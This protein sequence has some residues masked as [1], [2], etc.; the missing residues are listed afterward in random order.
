MKELFPNQKQYSLNSAIL[1]KNFTLLLTTLNRSPYSNSAF[2]KSKASREKLNF[3]QKANSSTPLNR[4]FFVR[5]IRTPQKSDLYR[6][7]SMVE[8][9]RHALSVAAF[10][11]GQFLTLLRSTAQTVRS[12]AVVLQ[13][14]Q[15]DYTK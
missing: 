5:S 9:N 1:Q 6:L 8:R 15:K 10:L 2:A 13:N 11:C 12:L 3:T 7:F 4:A 14:S